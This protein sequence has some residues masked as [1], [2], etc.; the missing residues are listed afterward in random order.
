[1]CSPTF[2][3]A[4]LSAF[5]PTGALHSQ[6]TIFTIPAVANLRQHSHCW[7]RLFDTTGNSTARRRLGPKFTLLR[8]QRCHLL[9]RLDFRS[10]L[11]SCRYE[12]AS[13]GHAI[14]SSLQ[15]RSKADLG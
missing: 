11:L 9:A 7:S 4:N 12:R 14:S 13:T 5:F 2:L 10:C 15:R 6:A 8:V 3:E 1:M